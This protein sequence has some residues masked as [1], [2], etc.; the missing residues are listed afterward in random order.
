VREKGLEN[1]RLRELGDKSYSCGVR[2][3]TNSR[4]TKKR[5]GGGE[6]DVLEGIASTGKRGSARRKSATVVQQPFLPGKEG[7]TKHRSSS[8]PWKRE[9]CTGFHR[10]VTKNR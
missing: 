8:S 3:D 9:S 5:G 1:R 4:E 10:V 2:G 7:L 6:R